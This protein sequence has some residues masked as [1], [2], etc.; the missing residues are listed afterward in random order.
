MRWVPVEADRGGV[1][2]ELAVARLVDR[3]GEVPD[4][5]G[6][7]DIGLFAEHGGH[8]SIAELWLA[9]PV[10]L[11]DP[12]GEQQQPVTGVELDWMD[13]VARRTH[14][15]EGQFGWNEEFTH[16]AVAQ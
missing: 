4:K 7:R 14:E 6:G 11:G 5:F 2:A 1:V 3:T 16:P 9:T 12:V 15:P 13:R 8:S 10:S